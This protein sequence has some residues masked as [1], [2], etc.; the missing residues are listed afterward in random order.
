MNE[1]TLEKTADFGA[2]RQLIERL[3]ALPT[4]LSAFV[5]Q[6]MTEFEQASTDHQTFLIG[7]L[8][9]VNLGG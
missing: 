5:R 8:V 7:E 9:G 4:A 1:V 3:T 2:M 6:W